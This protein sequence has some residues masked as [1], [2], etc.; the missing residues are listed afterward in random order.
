MLVLRSKVVRLFG[1]SGLLVSD[2]DEL[3]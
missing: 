1:Y 3:V 2:T